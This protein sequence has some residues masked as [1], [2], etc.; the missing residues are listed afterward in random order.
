MSS[1]EALPSLTRGCT[2]TGGSSPRTSQITS[3]N[4]CSAVSLVASRVLA[5]R[6]TGN[7]ADG[8]AGGGSVACQAVNK[9]SSEPC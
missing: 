2:R 8:A 4:S 7:V 1:F 5:A 6:C 3:I 9:T